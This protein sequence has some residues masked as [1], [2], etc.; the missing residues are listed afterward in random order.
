M[1]TLDRILESGVNFSI[2]TNIDDSGYIVE[3]SK[4]KTQVGSFQ[5]A[6]LV[7]VEKTIE[8]YND[9][10]F[11]KFYVDIRNYYARQFIDFGK[12]TMLFQLNM[13]N[14]FEKKHPGCWIDFCNDYKKNI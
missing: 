7:I 5:Q 9:C 3:I 11:S 10:Y 12:L 8:K 2:K 1:K 4:E 13:I 14:E 6:V